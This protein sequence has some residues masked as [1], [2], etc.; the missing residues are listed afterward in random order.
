MEQIYVSIRR[1]AT[2]FGVAVVTIRRWANQGLLPCFRT[3]GGHRRFAL[4]TLH[5]FERELYGLEEEGSSP[6]AFP[7]DDR[8][9]AIYARVSTQKQDLLGNL[10]RQKTRLLEELPE[11][12]RRDVVIYAEYGSGLNPARNALNRLLNAVQHQEISKIYIEYPDRLTRFGFP[13]LQRLCQIF[14]TSIIPLGTV[15]EEK[16]IENEL[17]E[18]LMMLMA[19]F[20]G[21]MYATR[22]HTRNGTLVKRSGEEDAIQHAIQK[23]HLRSLRTAIAGVLA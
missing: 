2:M 12:E 23:Y 11:H 3:A 13:F 10:E 8:H 14:H 22:A 9:V 1:A 7:E 6:E 17:V 19:H 18:D 5:A 4:K 20:S 16:T 21:K 15:M